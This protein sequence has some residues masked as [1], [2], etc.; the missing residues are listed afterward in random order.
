[1]TDSVTPG[2]AA[3]AAAALGGAAAERRPVRISGGGS[4]LGWG[5]AVAADA[6]RLRTERLDRVL[7]QSHDPT[8]A[9]L[10]AGT[11]LARV[12]IELARSGMMLAVD[13]QLGLGPTPA[14][15]VGGV[16]ATADSGPLA[17]GYGPTRDQILGVTLALSSGRLLQSGPRI[18][19]DASGYE[20]AKL[21]TG[22]FGTLGVLLSVEVRLHPLPTQTATA[23]GSS[24][25]PDLLGGAAVTLSRRLSGMQAFDVAWRGARG[26]LLARFAGEDA[27][28][29]ADAAATAM[30][31]CGLSDADSRA[32]DGSMWARQRA[33]Q[34]S[35]DR[36]VLRVHTRRSELAG[37]LRLAAR[38]EAGLVGRAALG[39][40]YLTLNVN[41]IAEVRAGLPAGAGTVV[42][43]LPQNARG[44]VESWSAPEG[45]ELGLMREIKQSFDPAGVCNPG[46]FVGRI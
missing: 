39:V 15:T 3:E 4:K 7:I 41:R 1:M 20:L 40:C 29:L 17:H 26:G 13:P 30:R 10:G 34:R 11:P 6:L 28:A 14:A 21:V 36:A 33:G 23:F 25:E 19:R 18:E 22:S 35:A 2:S 44:A 31:A 37:V 5:G 8:I 16:I 43:D 12:Q 27:P 42:L 46:V 24:G 38:A 32:D 45:P 9:T